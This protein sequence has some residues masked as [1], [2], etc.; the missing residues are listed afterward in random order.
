MAF[1]DPISLNDNAAAA[2]SFTRQTFVQQGSDWIESDATVASTRRIIIRHSNAGASV[3]KGGKPL[4]RHLV[5]FV[6][7]A[8]NA[9]LGKTEKATL[10]LTLTVDPGRSAITD[11][12]L[13]DLRSF[14]KEWLTTANIDK[15]LRDEA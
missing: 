5:Q 9:T 11:T 6:Q 2:Q 12:N 3:I 13:Y 7:E 4:R 1:T 10:N 8:W 15:V 14:A